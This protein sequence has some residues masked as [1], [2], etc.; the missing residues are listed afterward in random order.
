M[1]IIQIL[2]FAS[3]L[4]S[5]CLEYLEVRELRSLASPPP[6]LKQISKSEL[7]IVME[8]KRREEKQ[9]VFDYSIS[10]EGRRRRRG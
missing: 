5:V 4:L 8:E 10:I 1:I 6:L 3:L 7:V 2:F 9:T